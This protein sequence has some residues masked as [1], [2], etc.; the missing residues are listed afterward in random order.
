[1]IPAMLPFIV[2][3]QDVFLWEAAQS[4]HHGWLDLFHSTKMVSS[5][6]GFW[7]WVTWCQVRAVGWVRNGKDVFFCANTSFTIND[8]EL[9]TLSQWRTHILALS[10]HICKPS[11]WVS[12]MIWWIT[13][14]GIPTFMR[15]VWHLTG[16]DPEQPWKMPHFY[17]FL[18]LKVT[19]SV[20]HSLP[21]HSR[22]TCAN[23][24]L[25]LMTKQLLICLFSAYLMFLK[26]VL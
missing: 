20:V 15:L 5:K 22:T 8:V 12:V 16:P 14:F 25:Q 7:F 11:C 9:D 13:S 23:W 24:K 26:Y 21:F 19:L 1:M 3:V 17:W 18:T 2:A 4:H 10:G 6:G